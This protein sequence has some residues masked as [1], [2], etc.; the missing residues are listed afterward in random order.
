MCCRSWTCWC[1]NGFNGWKLKKTDGTQNNKNNNSVNAQLPSD[2]E[3]PKH[4]RWIRSDAGKSQQK[5]KINAFQIRSRTGALATRRERS[6]TPVNKNGSARCIIYCGGARV[7]TRNRRRLRPLIWKLENHLTGCLGPI[8]SENKFQLERVMD[9]W[10]QTQK[11]KNT[12]RSGAW[13]AAGWGWKQ[14]SKESSGRFEPR[15]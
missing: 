5:Y 15:F 10:A 4:Q 12:L 13:A 8:L 2:W 6:W 11:G 9:K 3:K 7:L 14:E 1:L